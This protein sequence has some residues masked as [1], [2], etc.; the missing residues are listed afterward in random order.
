MEGA[1]ESLKGQE[2]STESML[3]ESQ[4]LYRL[5]KMGA[6][7]NIY[8]KLPKSTIDSLEIN[9]VAGLVSAGRSSEV[10]GTLDLLRVKQLAVLNWLTILPAL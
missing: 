7:V 3:L 4:I 6:S 8:Q 1:L 9:L 2:G 10:Q 5:G